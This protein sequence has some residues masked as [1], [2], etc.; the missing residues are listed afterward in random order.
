[1]TVLIQ[2]KGKLW[3]DHVSNNSR[4]TGSCLLPDF[5]SRQALEATRKD[6][7]EKLPTAHQVDYEFAYDDVD[8]NTLAIPL[9]SLPADHPRHY[10]SLTRIRF[11]ARDL[12]DT[13]NPARLLHTW[14]GMT[15]FIAEVMQR[16]TYQSACPFIQLHL[17]YGRRRGIARLAL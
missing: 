11:L 1:M 7:I 9:E 6:G 8:D 10:K 16:P 15:K 14:P 2:K 12:M 17:N 4:Q 3:S 5:F 13:D